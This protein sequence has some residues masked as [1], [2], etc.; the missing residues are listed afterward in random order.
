MAD[1]ERKWQPREIESI[2]FDLDGLTFD[3]A[4]KFFERK[5]EEYADSQYRNV[6]LDTDRDYND[7]WN[8]I[9]KGEILETQ[10]QANLREAQER[11]IE[12]RRK[13]RRRREFEQLKKEFEK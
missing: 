9:I 5:K 11:Q 7:E 6:R 4:I 1:A 13:E 12:L 10:E 8:L 3:E 2:N